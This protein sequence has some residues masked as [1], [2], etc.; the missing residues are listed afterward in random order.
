MTSSS[1]SSSP[2]AS[3]SPGD[4]TLCDVRGEVCPFTF[5]R[6]KLALEALPVGARLR[7]LVDHAPAV[8][9][10]PRSAAEWGQEVEAVTLVAPST[11]AID[12]RKRVS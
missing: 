4:A 9:N 6:A 12:L 2:P 11:W 10:L 7:V 5:V 8:T 3:S 1:S